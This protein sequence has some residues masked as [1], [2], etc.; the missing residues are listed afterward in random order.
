MSVCLVKCTVILILLTVILLHLTV[1]LIQLTVI[2]KTDTVFRPTFLNPIGASDKQFFRVLFKL[3][4]FRIL[5]TSTL[6]RTFSWRLFWQWTIYRYSI[7]YSWQLFCYLQLTVILTVFLAGVPTPLC[8]VH[9]YSPPSWR[10]TFYTTWVQHHQLSAILNFEFERQQKIQI[11]VKQRKIHNKILDKK[12]KVNEVKWKITSYLR[13]ITTASVSKVI[14][15][16]E[17]KYNMKWSRKTRNQMKNCM[18]IQ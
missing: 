6:L 15:N 9:M 16:S 17:I 7:T 2:L 14:Q 5:F 4:I 3:Q 12:W 11:D 8:A 10:L 1:I 13:A 18:Y